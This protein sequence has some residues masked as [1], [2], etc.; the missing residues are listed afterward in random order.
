M[1]FRQALIKDLPKI[2]EMLANDDLGKSRE[3]YSNQLPSCYVKA[4]E[5]INDDPSS[6]LIVATNNDVVIATL[7]ITYIQNM[8]FKGGIRAQ[9]E[10]VR[11]ASDIRGKGVGKK[12]M[13]WAIEQAKENGCHLVQLTTNKGRNRAKNFYKDLGFESTHDGMKLYL[14][15][16]Q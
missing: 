3:S 5:I 9:I 14:K 10:G 8:T 16:W 15:P 12:I 11:V 7:Q 2:V 1:N 4:F 13:E 6:Q